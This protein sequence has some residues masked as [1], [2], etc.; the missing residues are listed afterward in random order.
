MVAADQIGEHARR[1]GFDLAGIAPPRPPQD[2]LRA[3]HRWLDR[4]DHGQMA[5][6]ARPDRIARREDPSIILPGVRAVVCV[7]VNY[8]PGPSP[9]PDG[10]LLRGLVS[11]YAWGLDYHDWMLPR[12]EELAAFIRAGVGG[13]VRHRAYVDTGPVLERAFATQA[14]LGF[15][16]KNTCL[17]HPRLGSWL[18]LGEVLVDADLVP[19]GPAAPPRCGTCTRCLDE[20]P[21]GAL[22]A[23][24]R[25]DARRCISYLTI[26]HR[27]PIPPDLRPLM[28]AW[29]YG[30]D[31]CQQVCPWQRF[32]RTTAIPSF[33]PASPDQAAPSL[34]E[35]IRLDEEG[36]RRRFRGSPVLRIGRARLLRNVAVALGNLGDPRAVDGLA[37]ALTD[38]EPLVRGH[39]AWALGRIGGLAAVGSLTSALE[40]E[41]DPAVRRELAAALAG[42]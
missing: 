39:A 32:A 41:A 12:L 15:V 20:C 28:G 18:F 33:R 5:Y 4:G 11:N 17:I 19:T 26:E 42:M 38:P 24:Y 9:G 23:P 7:A 13:E 3:Y 1:L 37:A 25:L 31:V 2:H 34:L 8:Y 6:M 10:P 16:G 21:T 35:L 14:G 30:C 22:A 27:G 40:R 29:I 36:F